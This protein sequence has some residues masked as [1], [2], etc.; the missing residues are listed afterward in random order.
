MPGH[1]PEVE[2]TRF[3]DI[4]YT[5]RTKDR[6]QR[7]RGAIGLFEQGSEEPDREIPGFPHI[8]RVYR[9][10]PGVQRMF[11]DEPFAVEEKLDGYNV[12]LFRHQGRLLASTRG[13]FICPFTTAWAEIWADEWDLN[14]FL[15][16]HPG[17]ALC[18]EVLGQN[19]YHHQ[20]DPALGP[21]AHF[22]LFE[23]V[24]ADGRF[25]MPEQR[26][27]LAERYGLP[28]APRYGTRSSHEI[29]A[30]LDLLR[31]L[32]EH[33]REGIVMKS[34][35]A[36]RYLK[37]VTP[38]SDINDIRDSMLLAFELPG[39]FFHNRWLR[40]AL[41]VR[42]LGLDESEYARR[43][44][45]AFLEGCP[46]SPEF[47]EASQQYTIQVPD[48]A[49]WKALYNRM[50]QQVKI[51]EDH[52]ETVRLRGRELLQVTFSRVFERSSSRYQRMLRGYLYTD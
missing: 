49:T 13:G 51:R 23:L 31:E 44:G 28:H 10:A 48:Q 42:E 21:G 16:D 45:A 2:H 24:D 22:F 32:N 1:K 34:L 11:R 20:A 26:Y 37:F 14:G 6:R 15:D 8:K 50:V 35:N 5:R 18:G 41:S 12:R 19:P 7:M 3:A 38:A 17:H 47:E 52:S 39:G 40:V 27:E 9:L 4:E 30:L 46:H 29:R 36:A 33:G 25:L 43:L